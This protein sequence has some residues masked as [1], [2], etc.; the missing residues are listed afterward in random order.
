MTAEPPQSLVTEAVRS[1]EVRGVFRTHPPGMRRQVA[2]GSARSRELTACAAS[3]CRT[4]RVLA[5]RQRSAREH[6][7]P[8]GEC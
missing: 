7:L 8:P 5:A 6:T 2:T 4:S 1:L 3:R